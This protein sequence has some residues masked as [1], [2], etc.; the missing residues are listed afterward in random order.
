MAILALTAWIRGSEAD[1]TA[2]IRQTIK[3]AVVWVNLGPVPIHFGVKL[4]SLTVIMFLMVALCS[5]C[6]HVFSI[7]YMK[8]DPRFARFFTFL[9]LF[10]FSMLG[11]VISSDLLLLFVF[12]ELVG[13]CS[14]F[15]IGF[16]FEKKSTA[17]RPSRRS[18]SIASA[19]SAS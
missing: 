3:N 18:S 10:C 17:T 1:H 12:W 16:W 5:T 9:S 2:W 4:D 19:T 15:L 13:V 7:G 14:Y 6:I 11:L 8:G